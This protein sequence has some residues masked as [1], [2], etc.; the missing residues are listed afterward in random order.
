MF[1][2]VLW[3]R[4]WIWTLAR[5]AMELEFYF[6][7][8][9]AEHLRPNVRT[10][11]GCLL[12]RTFCRR[13]LPERQFNDCWGLETNMTRHSPE[14]AVQKLL[15]DWRLELVVTKRQRG[16]NRAEVWWLHWPVPT[17]KRICFSL[18]ISAC[19]TYFSTRL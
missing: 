10:K 8:G 3:S 19:F 13:L 6:Q 2:T 14:S 17:K 1:M 5:E 7:R 16:E 4:I 15:G 18:A 9:P 12:G 11:R